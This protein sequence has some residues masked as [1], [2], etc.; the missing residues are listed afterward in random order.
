MASHDVLVLDPST[1]RG[2]F[3]DLGI[4]FTPLVLTTMIHPDAASPHSFTF[5]GDRLLPLRGTIEIDEMHHP[6]T[7]DQNGEPCIMVLKNGR[8][9]G[10][11]VGR[12]NNI[13]SYTRKRFGTKSITA[14]E[15]PILP[16][17]EDSGV[18]SK[19]GDS[20]SVVVDVTPISVVLKRIKRYNPLRG[21]ILGSENFVRFYSV[22]LM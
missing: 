6:K 14:R 7:Y 8:T 1:F 11:T 13:D 5:P 21:F 3:I 2:N 22:V 10:F 19:D 20:G 12:A 15:W 18:F 9:T 17:N 4:K 16:F